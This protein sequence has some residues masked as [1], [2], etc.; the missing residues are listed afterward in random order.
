MSTWND[1]DVDAAKAFVQL[2]NLH[3][4]SAYVTLNLGGLTS[5]AFL[6][7]AANGTLEAV[8]NETERDSS[9]CWFD[10]RM[11]ESMYGLENAFGPSRQDD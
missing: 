4:W 9:L 10:S 11:R 7:P 5:L 6:A 3:K 1:V 2:R 8:P